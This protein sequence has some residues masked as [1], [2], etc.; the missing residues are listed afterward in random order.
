MAITLYNTLTRRPEPFVPLDPE[1]VTMYLCGPTVYNYVHIGN[2]RGPVVF[3][4][5]TRLLRRHYPN[6]VFA[7]NITDVD[8]KINAAARE[9]GVSIGVISERFAGAY[10]EDMQRLGVAPPDI[11]PY[12]TRHMA[13]IIAMIETLIARGNA[14]VA[15]DH[16][17]FDVASWPD[18]GQLSGRS[19]E[20][21]LAGARVEVEAYKKHPGDFVLWKPSSDDLPGW[22]SPWGRGRPGWHIEC[23]AMSAAHLGE[24][25]DIHAGGVDLAFPHHENEIAQSTSAH[26]GKTFARWWLHNGMLTFA[27]AKMSKSLGNVLELH[28][29]LQQHPPEALRL[30]LLRAHYRQPLDWSDDTIHQ[31]VR[32]L[33]G[34]YGVLRD[35]QDVEADTD[36]PVPAS[37][38]AALCDDLNTPQALAELSTLADQARQTGSAEAKTALLAAGRALGLLQ[39]PPEDW[40]RQ[41]SDAIDAAAVEALIEERRQ[42]RADKHWARADAIRDELAAMG[43]VIEDGAGGTRWSTSRH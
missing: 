26:G 24:T 39:Q 18:Y 9:Q 17:L 20:D 41:G 31:A 3:D 35:M 30:L 22:D 28:A 10:H 37:V 2:A 42:A 38:E 21:M 15:E 12:A 43:V 36:A 29:L 33:D 1:R 16:V 6:V 14:Y 8:D 25:I 40:F 5:L 19:I 27:G 13:E 32:T 23:S 4:V 34:W 11:E 7:R